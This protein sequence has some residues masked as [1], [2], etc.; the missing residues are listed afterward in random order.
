MTKVQLI[1][2]LAEPLVELLKLHILDI[3]IAF[4]L[5]VLKHSNGKFPNYS[6]FSP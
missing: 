6:A 4:S 2:G 1:H 5:L 3:L